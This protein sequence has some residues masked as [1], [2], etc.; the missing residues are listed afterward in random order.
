MIILTK[1]TDCVFLSVCRS[2]T[3]SAN[4]IELKLQKKDNYTLEWVEID[5]EAFTGKNT[6][7]TSNFTTGSLS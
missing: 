5:K 3:Y 2:Q 4:E 7:S 1:N 6:H